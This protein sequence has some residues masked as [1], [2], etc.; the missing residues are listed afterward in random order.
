MYIFFV[1]LCYKFEI[2]RKGKQEISNMQENKQEKSP[3]KRRILIYL[4]Q[5]GVTPYE[6]YK[7]SG[8]TRGVLSQ[9]NGISEENLAR[10]LAYAEDVSLQWLIRGVGDMYVQNS[11]SFDQTKHDLDN[12][13]EK[14]NNHT[15]SVVDSFINALAAK[16]EILKQ[17]AEEIGRLKA[18]MEQLK[19]KINKIVGAANISDIASV[20]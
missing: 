14:E 12:R 10:F 9:D 15:Q 2:R 4:D 18:E 20:G 19:I 7:K 16:D 8:V 6:F 13:I 1:S 3:I 11:Y 5:K 17:Q